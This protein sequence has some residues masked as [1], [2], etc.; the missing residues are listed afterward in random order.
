MG[1]G[2]VKEVKMKAREYVETRTKKNHLMGTPT[3]L[4]PQ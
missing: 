2:S 3:R 4:Q 1:A